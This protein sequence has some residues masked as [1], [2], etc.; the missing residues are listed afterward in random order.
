MRKIVASA[1]S[2]TDKI[3]CESIIDGIRAALGTSSMKAILFH[4]GPVQLENPK[5]FHIKLF[6]IFGKGTEVLEKIIVKELF[7][8]LSLPYEEKRVFDFEGY[9]YYAKEVYTARM[10]DAARSV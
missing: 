5:E 8:R 7:R 2:S 6:L 4:L 1:I 3:L 10:K 9:V